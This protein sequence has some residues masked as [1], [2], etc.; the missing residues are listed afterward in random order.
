[1]PRRSGLDPGSPTESGSPAECGLGDHRRGDPVGVPLRY[2]STRASRRRPSSIFR[3]AELL[4]GRRNRPARGHLLQFELA[5][6][7]GRRCRAP[8][9]VRS[10]SRPGR[11]RGRFDDRRRERRRFRCRH[12]C[13]GAANGRCPRQSGLPPARRYPR[14]SQ[15]RPAAPRDARRPTPRAENHP[16][17]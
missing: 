16:N 9:G 13:R 15:G 12:S 7:R 5:N 4:R 14:H 11:T 10:R 1:M 17:H 8:S 6:S 3:R 2:R